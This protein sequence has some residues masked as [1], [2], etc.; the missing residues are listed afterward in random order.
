MLIAAVIIYVIL[1]LVTGPFWPF[2]LLGGKA[3]PLGYLLVI[4]WFILLIAGIV[5]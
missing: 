2:E 1:A 5:T 4:V 3:G